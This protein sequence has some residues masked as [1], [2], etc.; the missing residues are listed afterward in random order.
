M[1][2]PWPYP[3]TPEERARYDSYGPPPK[4]LGTVQ[5]RL[6]TWGLGDVYDPERTKHL[7][8]SEHGAGFTSEGDV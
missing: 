1:K 7:D 8:L 6:D 5:D 4:P 2:D 3:M